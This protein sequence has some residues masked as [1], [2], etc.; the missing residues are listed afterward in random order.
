MR[1]KKVTSF[2]LIAVFTAIFA[3]K[4][5]AQLFETDASVLMN[6]SEKYT[7]PSYDYFKDPANVEHFL[8][9]FY[10]GSSKIVGG[11]DVDIED[12]PWQVSV[13]MQPQFGGAHFCG[14]TIIGEE[15]I[16][17]AAHCVVHEN[18]QGNIIY[19]DPS[20]IRIRAGFTAMSSGQGTH[21]NVSEIVINPFYEPES[22]ITNFDLALIRVSSPLNLELETKAK[23]GLVTQDDAAA[24]LTDPGEMVKVSGWGRLS[25]GGPMPNILQ[26]I[27]VPIVHRNQTNYPPSWITSDMIIAGAPGQDACQGDSGGPMVVADGEGWYKVA[28]V[29][30]WGVSCGQ[31]GYPGVYARVSY[32]ENWISEQI[33]MPDPNQFYTFHYEDFGDGDIPAGWTN[34][35]IQ[36][37][38]DFPGWEWTLTGGNY[39]GTLN[40]TTADNGY[41]ILDSDAHGTAGVSEEV[42]LIT[43]AFD[44][45]NITTSAALSLE[46]RAR[47]FGNADIRIYVSNDDFNTQTELYRWHDAP[48]NDFN[49]PNPV[50]SEFDITDVAVG[51][52]NVKFKFKWLGSYDYWWLIDDVKILVENPPLEVNFLV[53]DG[54]QP[55][56]N[57]LVYTQYTDQE[58]TTD[59]NGMASLILYESEYEIFAEREGFFPYE[60]TIQ[61]THD[62]QL[63]EIIMDK[64]PAPEIEV[65]VTEIN[66]EVMLGFDAQTELTIS[67]PGD[68][69]LQ[70]YIFAIEP[71]EK[72]VPAVNTSK[73][74]HQ[75]AIY[76]GFEVNDPIGVYRNGMSNLNS[77]ETQVRS[78]KPD[79]PVEIH[80]DT[81]YDSG[82][83]TNSAASFITAARFTAEELSDYYGAY[84]L[85]A[86]KFHIRT[87]QFSEV[88]VKVWQGGSLDGP[89]TEIYSADVTDEVLIEEWTIYELSE[90]LSLTHGEEY[91]IGYA[92]EATGGFPASVDSGPMEPD[93][94]GWMFFNGA[95]SQLPELNPQLDFN[96]NIR[97]ILEPVLGVDWITFSQDAGIVEPENEDVI[98]ITFD[99]SIPE[100]ELGEHLANIHIANNAGET[101]IVPATMTVIPANFDVT[102]V[103]NDTDGNPIDDA[104][105]T[106]DGEAN[107]EGDYTFNNILIG[108]YAY[109]VTSD[110]FLD[111]TGNVMVVNQDVTVNVTMIPDDATTS[112]L[113]VNIE[114]EFNQ[115]VENA[116]FILDG[117]GNFLSD[118]DGEIGITIVDG[119]YD[120]T[121]TKFGM[122]D[123]SG[124]VQIDGDHTLNIIM[125]YLRYDLTL[126]AF[127]TEGGIVDGAGEY[128]HG[129]TATIL[130]DPAEFYNFSHW[131]E[132]TNIVSVDPEYSFEVMGNRH[133]VAN[134]QI[135]TYMITAEAVPTDSGIIDGVGEHDHGA[136]V[137]LTALP[138]TGYEFVEWTEDGET[139]EGVGAEYTFEALED[140]HLSA[141]FILS[142]YNLTFDIRTQGNQPIL[143][144]VIEFDGT[145]YPEGHYGFEDLL[146]GTYAYV[147][148]RD[149]YFDNSGNV[150]II[151]QDVNH[152]V[153]LSIDDTSIHE[154]TVMGL[155]IYPNPASSVLSI[156]SETEIEEIKVFDL[157]GRTLYVSNPNQ[158]KVDVPV[159]NL[160]NGIYLLQVTTNGNSTM[161]RFQKN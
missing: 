105:V 111:V 35:V 68:A 147:V 134:F 51:E 20:Q 160:N 81:G 87:N 41:L 66:I 60:S 98:T 28:G 80:Y 64:I 57:A 79:Q 44:L 117:F 142:T 129:E 96:W 70:Y 144:A 14:G 12:Y 61:V 13:Q 125:D 130:A 4:A 25:S 152:Q 161:L 63:I 115:P 149:E 94:G 137:T 54:E 158:L 84:E 135:F 74:T 108:S 21:Y 36:G 97:G 72:S 42:N 101:I 89:G 159:H 157:A 53:T 146:P 11:E 121:L 155:N 3:M 5:E 17:T 82:V 69:D 75:T 7:D 73:K 116:Y 15:W 16:L 104:V 83:G 56:S 143:D 154:A 112:T 93:K 37:P 62:G 32:F 76:D 23:V 148:S 48:Q 153:T 140:R 102:F 123:I 132:G 107:N 138:A 39:G 99:G 27:E 77:Q 2:L 58:T 22:S 122:E 141:H 55:L 113:S 38:A 95:W 47:T 114:D 8:Q 34:E 78:D 6:E 45:S 110:N 19:L 109:L 9:Q 65:D 50:Y 88:H 31:A 126:E 46:H 49:G 40:S 145:V 18:Q 33:M 90:N 120:Y 139:L 10:R 127:P 128:Y 59:A 71:A 103:I 26:A 133:L 24:G 86:I 91:W 100:I 92:M 85:G 150:V 151:N 43:T 124:T 52:S 30:S 118:S 156:T 131:S 106:L 119:Q 29:V 1:V 136:E 67:N